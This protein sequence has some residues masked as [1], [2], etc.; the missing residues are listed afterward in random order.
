MQIAHKTEKNTYFGND[1]VAIKS[2][3]LFYYYKS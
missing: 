1:M 2:S 3:I